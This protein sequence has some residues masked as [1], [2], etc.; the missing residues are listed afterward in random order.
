VR[1]FWLIRGHLSEGLGWAEDVL[2]Q[3]LDL[4]AEIRWKLLTV[5]GNISQFHG[6]IEKSRQFYEE[7]LS[8]AR[9]SGNQRYIAQSLRGV[10][11]VAY[12]QRDLAAARKL[13]NEAIELSRSVG[14]EFGTAAA[15]A[16]LGDIASVED[17]LATAHSLTA[18]SL[19]IFR[20]IGYTEG[21]SA[22]L[23]NLGAIVFMEG[24]HES[25]RQHFEEAHRKL[26]ELGEK[27]NTRLIF[28]GF[29]ALAAERG[30]HA[31]A[32]RLAG[33]AESL[34]ATIG[35]AIEPAEQRF[36]DAYLGKLRAAM[37]ESEFESGR[38]IGRTLS[39]TQASELA[40]LRSDTAEDPDP[41]EIH[42]ERLLFSD[43]DVSS[44]QL[45]EPKRYGKTIVLIVL[46]VV[47]FVGAV[48]I[49]L[50]LYGGG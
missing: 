13:I 30:D 8:S 9:D 20:R 24:D 18:E 40:L 41:K 15:L 26:V 42:S 16:R 3:K 25:A 5:C 46:L 17:D 14:D 39:T 2:D 49:T 50:W 10:G 43:D 6:D 12:L 21:I 45:K 11:A 32:A 1:H 48:F 28:D 35:Y 44:H 7:A 4:P 27:I 36:R 34:G 22:K 47:L 38:Q 29:A 31:R 33:A 19:S 37:S 23:Y